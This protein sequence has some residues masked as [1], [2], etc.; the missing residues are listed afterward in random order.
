MQRHNIRVHSTAAQLPSQK[1]VV[2]FIIKRAI[3][4]ESQARVLFFIFLFLG[5]KVPLIPIPFFFFHLGEHH[6]LHLVILFI[7]IHIY[8]FIL[9]VCVQMM[10]RSSLTL[11]NNS[12]E[13]GLSTRFSLKKKKIRNEHRASQN[14][15]KP[16]NH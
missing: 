9:C 11:F 1:S 4:N 13:R 14:N 2:D 5:S 8:V 15:I 6:Y 12:I 16:Q 7:Y 3:N 10:M